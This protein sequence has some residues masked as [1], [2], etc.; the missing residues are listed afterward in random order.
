M[1]TKRVLD[2]FQDPQNAG[3]MKGANG[4]G[5]VGGTSCSDVMKIY[6]LIEDG[7][8]QDATFKTFGSC[9]AIASTDVACELV[10]GRTLQE[11][12]NLTGT[13]ILQEL[14]E[15]PQNKIYTTVLAEQAVKAALDD[16]YK[17]QEKLKKKA[18]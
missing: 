9:A 18:D 1:Y 3:G 12:A 7:V 6:L 15:L 14:G 2:I 5:K 11:A 16:Y 10:K 8:V 4:V 17:R 13:E